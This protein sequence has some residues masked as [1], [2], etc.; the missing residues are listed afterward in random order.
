MHYQYA[1][2]IKTMLH[3]I[4]GG[5][6]PISPAAR[7]RLCHCT[8]ACMSQKAESVPS[9]KNPNILSFMWVHQKLVLVAWI[10]RNSCVAQC[11]LL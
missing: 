4:A 6:T 7:L 10:E 8:T 3:W 11:Q 2:E 1:Q 5:N 9:I